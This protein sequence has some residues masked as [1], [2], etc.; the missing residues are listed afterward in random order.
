MVV[1]QPLCTQSF[2]PG[3]IRFPGLAGWAPSSRPF[4]ASRL[5]PDLAVVLRKVRGLERDPTDRTRCPVFPYPVLTSRELVTTLQLFS[6]VTSIYVSVEGVFRIVCPHPATGGA[7]P[8]HGFLPPSGLRLPRS[9]RPPLSIVTRARPLRRHLLRKKGGNSEVVIVQ[10]W[11]YRPQCLCL[12]WLR[13]FSRTR[14]KF[15]ALTGS[16]GNLKLKR[17]NS[18]QVIVNY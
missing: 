16:G 13:N 8:P 10:L 3:R 9:S 5:A 11:S 2:L 15:I 4:Q 12:A 1:M 14:V 18:D 17:E 6:S 7:G